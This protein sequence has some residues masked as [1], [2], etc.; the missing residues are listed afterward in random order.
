[1]RTITM[2]SFV[3]LLLISVA[4]AVAQES[5]QGTIT[6]FVSDQSQAALVRAE[7]T[8]TS[9][10][11]GLSRKVLTNSEGLYV[12]VGLQPGVYNAKVVAQGFK[13]AEAA[14]LVV[15]VG[16]S[17]RLN[18]TLEPG[19]VSETVT[20]QAEVGLQTETG[21]VSNLISGLQVTDVA[22]NGRN[23]TQ[24]L[25]LG[26]GVSSAQAGRQMGLGQEGNPLMAV[27]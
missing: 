5:Q 18:F 2:L 22:L 12:V 25:T 17:V 4:T 21:E 19:Q 9:Q 16:A 23:F 6:G 13:T 10:S 1:M 20:V 24:F 3:F 15:N 8:V 14:G 26:T 7:V 11:T 27:H